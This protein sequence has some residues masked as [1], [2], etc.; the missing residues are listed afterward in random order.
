[1]LR[2]SLCRSRGISR[3]C[4]GSFLQLES[5]PIDLCFPSSRPS[6]KSGRETSIVPGSNG[7]NCPTKSDSTLD[8]GDSPKSIKLRKS[9][10]RGSSFSVRRPR[11]GLPTQGVSNSPPIHFLSRANLD[12]GSRVTT[13]TPPRKVSCGTQVFFPD[14]SSWGLSP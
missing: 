13:I 7:P 4:I 3:G 8:N 2:F 5:F 10:G 14:K 12:S 9:P 11:S 1:M 6:S